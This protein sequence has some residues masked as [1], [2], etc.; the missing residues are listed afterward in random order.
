MSQPWMTNDEVRLISEFINSESVVLEYGS[1]G[2][3]AWFS[4]SC[5]FVLSIEHNREWF[6]ITQNSLREKKNSKLILVEPN[7]SW[8][9]NTKYDGNEFEF[10]DYIYKPSE[11]D[12]NPDFVLI[13]GRA[14]VDCCKFV[15]EKYPNAII[16]V[17]DYFGREKDEFH[18]YSK[19]LEFADIIKRAGTLAILTS[20]LKK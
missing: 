20:R 7:S 6:E 11:F 3:T 16:A 10:H 19:I 12:I 18:S 4:S 2:S 14:R 17:H 13:D 1:G 8:D 15:S 9:K 5:K